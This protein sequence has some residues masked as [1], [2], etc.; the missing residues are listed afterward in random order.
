MKLDLNKIL[1]LST[2]TLAI[3]GIFYVS[4]NLVFKNNYPTDIQKRN[5]AQDGEKYLKKLKDFNTPQNPSDSEPT[6]SNIVYHYN[7]TL[8]TCLI[9][10]TISFKTLSMTFIDDVLAGEPGNDHLAYF[11]YHYLDKNEYGGFYHNQSGQSQ[12]LKTILE[13]N[14]I[15]DSLMK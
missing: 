3:I 10:G 2:I 9:S 5:C 1:K 11:I 12:E 13:Y 14:K 4:S 7:D 15:N 6:F 8:K